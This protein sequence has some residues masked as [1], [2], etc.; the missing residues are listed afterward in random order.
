MYLKLVPPCLRRVAPPAG[1][2]ARGARAPPLAPLHRRISLLCC[3]HLLR[4]APKPMSLLRRVVESTMTC[5]VGIGCNPF[6]ALRL[7]GAWS[8]GAILCA[9]DGT[10]G[11]V[12]VGGVCGV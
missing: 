5:C 12:H 10:G 6:V 9:L 8:L 4:Q 7:F 11:A 1:A 3:L 2:A